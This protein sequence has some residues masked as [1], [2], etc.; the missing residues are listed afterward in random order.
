MVKRDEGRGG[1]DEP[2]GLR[3]VATLDD[4]DSGMW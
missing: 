2:D 3:K 1:W 4:D